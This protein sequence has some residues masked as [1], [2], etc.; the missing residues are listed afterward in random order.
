MLTGCSILISAVVSLFPADARPLPDAVPLLDAMLL[1]DADPKHPMDYAKEGD[2]Y[3]A[4][5]LA[6]EL[7]KENPEDADAFGFLGEI[8]YEMTHLED[9]REALEKA[10]E[11]APDRWG[12]RGALTLSRIDFLE[13]DDE[14]VRKS[15]AK[16]DDEA[17]VKAT[18]PQLMSP[19]EMEV[20][21]TR[22][23]I[24]YADPGMVAKGGLD[25]AAQV[26]EIVHKSYTKVI[27]FK[28]D[29][30]ISR[31]YVLST[32]E[33]Y[34]AFNTAVTGDAAENTLGYFAPS[35]RIL[36]INADPRDYKE[37]YGGITADSMDTMFHEG[38]HQFARLHAPD[39]HVWF[40]EGMAEYFG[41]GGKITRKSLTYGNVPTKHPSRLDNIRWSIQGE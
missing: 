6:R 10:I 23:Y 13:G 30:T 4:L 12:A 31:V 18:L 28:T 39:I 19:P 20:K 25:A 32:N 15:L 2:F 22:N 21:R 35:L 36:V 38:F 37:I 24:V 33:K 41:I 3:N 29:K 26:M 14:A 40:N 8:E 7:A 16:V 27:P 1:L 34:A 5:R 9:S 11:L 17:W